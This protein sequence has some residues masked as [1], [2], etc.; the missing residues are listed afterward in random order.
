MNEKGQKELSL[1]TLFCGGNGSKCSWTGG[2]NTL[3]GHSQIGFFHSPIVCVLWQSWG[4][5][6]FEVLAVHGSAN[7]VRHA[8]YTIVFCRVQAILGSPFSTD[9]D[10]TTL[11]IIS[12]IFY[13]DTLPKIEAFLVETEKTLMRN[14][15]GT[16]RHA[17]YGHKD[18]PLFRLLALKYG[19]PWQAVRK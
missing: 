7:H 13:G 1:M 18:V 5:K 14:Q 12:L 8:I 2:I 11:P 10:L 4:C 16:L 17:V 19:T 15:Y 6:T 3:I 9:L